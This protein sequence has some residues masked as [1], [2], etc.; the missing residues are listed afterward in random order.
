MKTTWKDIK[1]FEGLY[2]INNKGEIYST[3]SNKKIKP[4]KQHTGYYH[5]SLCKNGKIYQKR[6]HRLVAQTF[7]PNFLNKPD[8][9][10]IDMNKSNNCVENLEW[11]TKKE[12]NQKMF[13][14]KPPRTNTE[15]RKKTQLENIKK[16]TEKNKKKVGQF[17]NGKLIKIYD[18]ITSVGKELKIDTSHISSCCKGKP[19]YKT[20]HGFE[21]K[22]M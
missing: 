9:N 11:V 8:V 14:I 21:W 19:N 4:I 17:K 22:Y 13:K 3:K 18:S 2:K 6:V 20:S 10:H 12:N 7:I 1:N 15:K 16:A 5:V